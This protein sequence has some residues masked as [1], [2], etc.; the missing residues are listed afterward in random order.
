MACLLSNSEV[1]AFN[2]GSKIAEGTPEQVQS[3]PHVIEA[4]LGTA[5]E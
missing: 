3:D 2:F 4:Y 1:N 5:E